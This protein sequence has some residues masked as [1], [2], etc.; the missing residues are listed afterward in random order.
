MTPCL[1]SLLTTEREVD[2]QIDTFPYFIDFSTDPKKVVPMILMRR[3]ILEAGM[4]LLM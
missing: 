2:R 1:R 4:V 3:F